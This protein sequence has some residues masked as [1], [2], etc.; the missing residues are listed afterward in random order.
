[1][2]IEYWAS[3]EREREKPGITTLLSKASSAE[4]QLKPF[5]ELLPINLTGLF[6]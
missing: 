2:G 4:L 3:V 6:R 5:L 1:V